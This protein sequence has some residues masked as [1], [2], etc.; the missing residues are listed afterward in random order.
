ME[1]APWKPEFRSMEKVRELACRGKRI[2]LISLGVLWSPSC[3]STWQA[4]GDLVE[5]QEW[6]EKIEAYYINQDAAGD[7]AF[8]YAWGIT[9]GFPALIVMID[10]YVVRIGAAERIDPTFKGAEHKSERLVRQLDKGQFREIALECEKIAR[11]EAEAV[12][13]EPSF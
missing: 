10:G 1:V 11:E 4:L 8:C 7:T 3:S 5:D 12:R 13:F 2:A 9:I 6:S